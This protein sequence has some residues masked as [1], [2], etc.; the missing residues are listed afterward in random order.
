[1]SAGH[2]LPPNTKVQF[3][4]TRSSDKFVLLKSAADGDQEQYKLQIL[5]ISL[6]VPVGIMSTKMTQELMMKWTHTDIQYFYERLDVKILSMPSNKQEYLS[7]ALFSEFEHPSR[8]YIML[9]ETQA[10]LGS[11]TLSPFHFGRKWTV[12]TTSTTFLQTSF[13]NIERIHLLSA[14]EKL[15]Q[16]M[17]YVIAMT[18]RKKHE[19]AEDTSDGD[20]TDSEALSEKKKKQKRPATRK[21]T[22]SKGKKTKKKSTAK[23]PQAST[24]A[25]AATVPGSL[26]SI[27]SKYPKGDNADNQSQTS[28]FEVLDEQAEGAGVDPDPKPPVV[29]K[30]DYWLTKCQLEL[31]S[32]P[33][34]QFESLQTQDE[35]M[36]GINLKRYFPRC[37]LMLLL[38]QKN[39]RQLN[40]NIGLYYK[41]VKIN[42]CC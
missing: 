41:F 30:T 5:N 9:V 33:L 21:Q 26:W 39:K 1:M 4:L 23:D 31:N 40:F 11:Y 3:S 20:T 42:Q 18:E 38:I 12:E 32:A 34:N 15:K 8:V 6:Y 7:D 16:E 17:S 36:A 28:S 14:I 2:F 25:A 13:E 10:C 29:I 22:V 24:S 19:E 37:H 35:A 27:F